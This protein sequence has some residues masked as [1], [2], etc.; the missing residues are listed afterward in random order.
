MGSRFGSHSNTLVS[1][2]NFFLPVRKGEWTSRDL[3]NSVFFMEISA[4]SIFQVSMVSSD[5]K[6]G[7]DSPSQIQETA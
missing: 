7:A 3:F 2:F 6:N 5:M 1:F 4:H